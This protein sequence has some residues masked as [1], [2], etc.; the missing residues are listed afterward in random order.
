MPIMPVVPESQI[1]VKISLPV[2]PY[3]PFLSG[4]NHGSDQMAH[5]AQSYIYTRLYCIL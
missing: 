1:K 5:T 3:R 4:Y 2:S